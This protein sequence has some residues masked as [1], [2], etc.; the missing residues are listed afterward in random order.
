MEALLEHL[1]KIMAQ[2]IGG[3]DRLAQLL[4]QEQAALIEHDLERIQKVSKAKETL[5]L[6]IKLLLPAV[7][8][9]IQDTARALGLS[10]DPLPTMAELAAAAP[11]PWAGRLRLAGLRLAR[12]KQSVT[13]QNQAN[14]AYVQEAL[15]LIS[16][17]I[18]I[19][20]GAAL[21]PKAGYMRNGQ[22]TE[23]A[24]HRPVRLSREV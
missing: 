15:D 2:H 8:Q 14:H 12:L 24:G 7:S 18:A 23:A 4:L 17:S 20:T 3:Y 1:T 21:A 16:G 22:T 19:L 13:M 10:S 11:D 9:A 6:K 5:A